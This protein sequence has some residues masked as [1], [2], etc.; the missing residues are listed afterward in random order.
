MDMGDVNFVIGWSTPTFPM[1][2]KVHTLL[3]PRFL[4]GTFTLDT[5]RGGRGGPFLESCLNLRLFKYLHYHRWRQKSPF[6]FHPFLEL[7]AWPWELR[8][9]HNPLE[10]VSNA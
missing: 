6:S 5:G 4:E 1:K 2:M 8:P 7:R 10:F 9:Q 3:V